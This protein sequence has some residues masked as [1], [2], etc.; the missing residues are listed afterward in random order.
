MYIM[1]TN[2]YKVY[3]TYTLTHTHTRQFAG[4]ELVIKTTVGDN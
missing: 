1:K 3:R 4:D 2:V